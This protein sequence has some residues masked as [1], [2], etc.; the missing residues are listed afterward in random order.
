MVKKVFQV[1]KSLI[2][3]KIIKR[4]NSYQQNKHILC[5]PKFISY[6]VEN[7]YLI[8]YLAIVNKMQA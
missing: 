6:V 8:S 5:Q 2:C 7:A 3:F 4:Y 1:Q